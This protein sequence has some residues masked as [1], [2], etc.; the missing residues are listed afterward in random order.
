M[1]TKI[2]LPL[3][4]DQKITYCDRPEQ[5]EGPS[6][7][8]WTEINGHLGTNAQSLSELVEQLGNA[9]FGHTPRVGD[10]FCGG[11]S[12]PFE[13]ARLG[14]ETYGSDLNPVGGSA[15][16]GCLDNFGRGEKVP[17]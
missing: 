2:F 14:C 4:Y 8:A 11:G 3:P 6:A 13:A 16:L 10:A 15:Q 1:Q 12:I 9:Q 7:E 17:G 5:I